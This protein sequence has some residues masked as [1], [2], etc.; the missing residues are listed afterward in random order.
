LI[1]ALTLPLRLPAPG[2]VFPV[3]AGVAG[4]LTG[5]VFP[6]AA[7]LYE[8]EGSGRVAG[9]LYGADLIG[10]CVGATTASAVL[11]PVLGVVQT[12]VGVALVGAAGMLLSITIDQGILVQETA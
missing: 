1:L 3:L 8:P 5:A 6:L 7:A 10:G 2:F 12:C 11:V 9:L 4:A